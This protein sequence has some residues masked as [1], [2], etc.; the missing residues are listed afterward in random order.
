ME[1]AL[2]SQQPTRMRYIITAFLLTVLP[3]TAVRA[4]DVPHDH[5]I[6]SFTPALRNIAVNSST[7]LSDSV[8]LKELNGKEEEKDFKTFYDKIASFEE[9]G[10]SLF[11][12]QWVAAG[13]GSTHLWVMRKPKQ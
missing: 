4:Q 3:F 13:V 5:L 9:Q 6:I 7:G 8:Q 10:W 12:T 1:D 11:S 2:S